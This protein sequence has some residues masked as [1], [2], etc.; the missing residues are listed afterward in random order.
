MDAGLTA[1]PHDV[2]EAIEARASGTVDRLAVVCL[3]L[4]IHTLYIAVLQY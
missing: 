3:G 1:H 2:L 4:F